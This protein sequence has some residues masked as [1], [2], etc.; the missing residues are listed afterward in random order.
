M[1]RRRM[2]RI[3]TRP[4][5]RSQHGSSASHPL[6]PNPRI[7]ILTLAAEATWTNAPDWTVASHVGFRPKYV[8]TMRGPIKSAS[9]LEENLLAY[10]STSRCA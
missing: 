4:R 9:R 2:H 5:D 6:P 10:E 8:L 1:R 3:E 7:R